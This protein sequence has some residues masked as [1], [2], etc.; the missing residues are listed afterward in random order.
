MAAHCLFIFL[1]QFSVA[2]LAAYCLANLLWQSYEF[3]RSPEGYLLT[4]FWSIFCIN[5]VVPFPS[6]QVMLHQCQLVTCSIYSGKDMSYVAAQFYRAISSDRLTSCSG[7][8]ES[9]LSAKRHRN[10][11]L[12]CWIGSDIMSLMA[13]IGKFYIAS[14]IHISPL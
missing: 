9:H 11:R 13:L 7:D 6:D 3:W 1:W 8:G 14:Y 4:W 2:P 10:R 12:L 5:L